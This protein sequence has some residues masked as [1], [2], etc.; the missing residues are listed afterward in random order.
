MTFEN[1]EKQILLEKGN[2]LTFLVSSF[3]VS[4]HR[5]VTH[6]PDGFSLYCVHLD[7]QG[8]GGHGEVSGGT[9]LPNMAGLGD[10]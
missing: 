8:G 10:A 5:W 1:A 4:S 7:F 6:V 3:C 9:L 2:R